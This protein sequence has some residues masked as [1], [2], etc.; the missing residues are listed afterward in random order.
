VS[1][2]RAATR[3]LGIATIA[4]CS[5]PAILIA[6][7]AVLPY[8]SKGFTIDDVTFLLQAKHVLGDALHPTAF[9]VVFD[10]VRTRLS[11]D[12]V[13]G[14]VMA[15]LL[16]PSVLLGGSEWLAHL[17]QLGLLLIA[18]GST[19]A[20]GFRLGFTPSQAAAA[21]IVLVT[22]PAV[23]GMTATAMP[24]VAAMAFGV[25]G[26]ERALAWRQTARLGSGVLSGVFFALAALA[27]PHLLLLPGCAVPWLLP[28]AG[29]RLFGTMPASASS[30]VKALLPVWVAFT[31]TAGAAYVFRDPASG[32]TTADATLVRIAV[33]R[34]MFNLSSFSLD[35]VLALPL[36]PLWLILR[37]RSFLASRYALAGLVAGTLLASAGGSLNVGA[38][39]WLPSAVFVTLSCGVFAHILGETWQHWDQVQLGLLLWLLIGASAAFYVQ[40][41]PKVLVPSAPAMA[42]LAARQLQ[43]DGP[44]NRG[45]P[46][47]IVPAVLGLL[48][49]VLIIR[50]DTALGE[51]GQAGGRR[52]AE[53]RHRGG[54]IWMDGHWGF[55][56]Y[57]MRAGAEPM[58]NTPP[59]PMPGDIVVAGPGSRLVYALFPRKTLLSREVFA[60]AGGRVHG[61]GAGFFTNLA[62]PLPWIWGREEIGRI[63][64]WRIDSVPVASR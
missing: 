11:R 4:R 56:W 59:Y 36:V 40:L 55:Q 50:A 23:L 9:D 12:L 43:P 29:E 58:A 31:I 20:L 10:G 17:I 13:S 14:P 27:R 33:G 61:N 30:L 64:V 24:D 48:L 32:A 60:Q 62:G 8:L 38:W 44:V 35:W 7:A 28:K 19:G 21:A 16:V 2:P 34:M 46:L 51:V 53:Y 63:E 18:V 54:R 26:M 45:Y 57:A 39:W 3:R 49:G 1:T 6:A 37:T 25:V 15:Y 22:S 41:P 52:V 5:A 42:L 47:L